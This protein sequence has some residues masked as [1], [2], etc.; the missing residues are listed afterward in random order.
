[1]HGGLKNFLRGFGVEEDFPEG[2]V[3]G[4]S[5]LGEA[6]NGRVLAVGGRRTNSLAGGHMTIDPVCGME[7][8]EKKSGDFRTQ[9]AGRKY[10]FCSEDCRKEFE[11]DPSG[12][13]ETAAA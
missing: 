12:Y 6:E 9:F 2:K 8:D 5:H 11:A 4:V 7:V 10:F 3:N 13:L 1:V